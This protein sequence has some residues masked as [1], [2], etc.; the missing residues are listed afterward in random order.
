MPRSA[1][2]THHCLSWFRHILTYKSSTPTHPPLHVFRRYSRCYIYD[3]VRD[4]SVVNTEPSPPPCAMSHFSQIVHFPIL[5]PMT[6]WPG[7]H[8]SA[9]PPFPRWAIVGD[10]SR[11]STRISCHTYTPT[12]W[13][14]DTSIYWYNLNWSLRVL[15]TASPNWFHRC[16]KHPT[17]PAA[18]GIIILTVYPGGFRFSHF[19]PKFDR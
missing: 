18:G 1:N 7:Q 15:M 12:P 19:H 13:T 11:I 3:N 2:P 9:P 16:H 8:I 10:I 14:W 4:N 5:S 17:P 6:T